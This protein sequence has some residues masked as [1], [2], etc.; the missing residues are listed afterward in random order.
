M[1]PKFRLPTWRLHTTKPYDSKTHQTPV[2]ERRGCCKS[3]CFSQRPLLSEKLQ[4]DKKISTYFGCDVSKL[5]LLLLMLR[6]GRWSV[7]NEAWSGG[8]SWCW[9][10]T[11]AVVVCCWS[12]VWEVLLEGGLQL[13]FSQS[14]ITLT[15]HRPFEEI[16]HLLTFNFCTAFIRDIY[17]WHIYTW[18]I[19]AWHIFTASKFRT[20]NKS[21]FLK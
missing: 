2:W 6:S 19:Y 5:L 18:H 9:D 1:S 12:L 3:K 10:D 14:L 16:F 17:M 13:A 11:D 15:Q 20:E 21:L 8:W 7:V 4:G